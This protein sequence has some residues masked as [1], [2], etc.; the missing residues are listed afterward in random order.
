VIQTDRMTAFGSGDRD[1]GWGGIG[2]ILLGMLMPGLLIRRA[3]SQANLL[4]TLRSAFLSFCAALVMFGVVLA[5]IVEDV[6]DPWAE[7]EVVAAGVAALGFALV[8]A[9]WR[10]ARLT[11]QADAGAMVA[12]YRTRFFLRI[13]FAESAALVGFVQVFLVGSLLPYLAGLV[14]AAVGFARLAPT[15][16]NLER[17]DDD[18]R[19]EGCPHSIHDLLCEAESP[20]SR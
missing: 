16:G 20:S 9:S 18:L 1:P 5:F 3:G 15:R 10:I 17:D 4:V 6:A 11:C 8:L 7:P 2:S 12:A 19:T 13:A 14:P